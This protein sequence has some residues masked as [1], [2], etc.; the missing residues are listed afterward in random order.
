MYHFFIILFFT[1]FLVS[2]N[3]INGN[4]ENLSCVSDTKEKTVYGNSMN[5]MLK[6]GQKVIFLENY[7]NCNDIKRNDLIAYDYSG[8]ALDLIKIIKVLPTD[9]V[10]ID[11]NKLIVNGEILK[12]SVGDIY[13]FSDN[14][15]QILSMYIK[16]NHIPQDSYFIFGDNTSSSIDS[17]KFGAINK[18]DILGKFKL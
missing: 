1:I 6:H 8:D 15:I 12:N 18:N 14:E 13:V 7:Y 2:C 11:K 16:D 9:I 17:R 5:P 3:N 4:K 10:Y